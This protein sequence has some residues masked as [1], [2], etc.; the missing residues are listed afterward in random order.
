L[1]LVDRT[2][3][4]LAPFLERHPRERAHRVRPGRAVAGS[5][6]FIEPPLRRRRVALR[7]LLLARCE[8]GRLRDPRAG[9]ILEPAPPPIAAQVDAH[10]VTCL[11]GLGRS[12]PRA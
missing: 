3:A 8:L 4:A 1:L 7:L 12:A 10:H 5:L 9:L 11:P 6:A 2:H